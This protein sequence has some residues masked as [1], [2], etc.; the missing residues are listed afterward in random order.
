MGDRNPWVD[1]W[2][3]AQSEVLLR[4]DQHVALTIASQRAEVPDE[5]LTNWYRLLV[6]E[7]IKLVQSEVAFIDAARAKGWADEKI[8][9]LLMVPVERLDAYRAEMS[10]L[11][12]KIH[13]AVRQKE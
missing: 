1:E 9:D 10:E 8:A 13:Y 12:M 6:M 11:P 5:V 3:A 2:V 4:G 7:R